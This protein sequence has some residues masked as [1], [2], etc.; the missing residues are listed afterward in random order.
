MNDDLILCLVVDVVLLLLLLAACVTGPEDRRSW[1][2]GVT[3]LHRAIYS[4]RVVGANK[5]PPPQQM[6]LV[7]RQLINSK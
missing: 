1:Q 6:R 5:P 2:V 3:G 7:T 4:A